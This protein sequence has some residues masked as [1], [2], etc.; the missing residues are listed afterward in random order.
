MNLITKNLLK[1][2]ENGIGITHPGTFHADDVLSACLIRLIN[3]SFKI[4]RSNV[5][6][7]NFNGVIFDIGLGRY[8]HHQENAE[9]RKDGIKYAAFGLLWRD[10]SIIFMDKYHSDMFD[11]IFISEIDRC[12]NSSD[13]NLLSNLIGNFNP[14]W[15]GDENTDE[16]FELAIQTF[17]PLLK[18]LINHFKISTF[19]FHTCVDIDQYIKESLIKIYYNKTGKQLEISRFVPAIEI[20]KNHYL[21]LTP[22]KESEFFERIFLNQVSKVYGKFKTSPFILMMASSKKDT[23][24]TSLIEMITQTLK[25]INALEPAKKECEKIYQNSERKDVIILNKYIPYSSMTEEHENIKIVIFPS[26]RNGYAMFSAFM[27]INEKINNKLN[28]KKSYPRFEFPMIL[29][30]KSEEELRKLYPGL[31]FVHPAGH[32]ASCDTINDCI[33]LYEKI[34]KNKTYLT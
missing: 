30:G 20:W 23:C 32:M 1:K 2:I 24:I 29:R 11:K 27:N 33:K 12:D 26:D 15:N 5:I 19:A 28:P 31:F 16:N 22:E 34:E 3:P 7:N 25:M 14:V 18:N 6:P 17:L 13:T 10:L 9:V 21:E 4:I 8:D